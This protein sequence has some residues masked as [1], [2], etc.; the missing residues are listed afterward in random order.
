VHSFIVPFPGHYE[1]NSLGQPSTSPSF[2][3]S[4]VFVSL[5]VPLFVLSAISQVIIMPAFL[6]ANM[7][8]VIM[9]RKPALGVPAPDLDDLPRQEISFSIVDDSPLSKPPCRST[10]LALQLERLAPFSTQASCLAVGLL[11]LLHGVF[12]L[13]FPSAFLLYSFVG[14][15]RYGGF[16]GSN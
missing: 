15:L 4:Y 7:A 5:S 8:P 10:A 14:Q 1:F 13:P 11:P 16:L 9:T 12:P 2:P 6:S 3:L